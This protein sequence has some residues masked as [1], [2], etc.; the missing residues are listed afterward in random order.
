MTDEYATMEIWENPD[1]FRQITIGDY[2]VYGPKFQ[3]DSR[4]IERVN[5]RKKDIA[6]SVGAKL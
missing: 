3:G 6:S 2:R 1:G 4:L 5:V